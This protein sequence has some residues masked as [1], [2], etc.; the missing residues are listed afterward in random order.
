MTTLTELWQESERRYPDKVAVIEAGKPLTYRQLGDRI[1]RVADG[2]SC[3]WRIQPGD[4]VALLVPNG[5]E[6]VISYFAIV[7]LG[8]V[9]QPIDERITSEEIAMVLRDAGTRFLIVHGV[10]WAK[11]D[12]ARQLGVTV[13]HLL[14]I[15]CERDEVETFESWCER[16]TR[17]A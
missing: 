5:V 10:L 11:F 1:R 6:F 7:R 4:I 14:G 9:V 8:A 15:A 16:P 12:A 13:D 2:L 3:Q 17:R